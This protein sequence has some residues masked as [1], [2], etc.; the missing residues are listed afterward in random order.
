MQNKIVLLDSNDNKL[1]GDIVAI[2]KNENINYVAYTIPSSREKS[3]LLVSKYEKVGD[4]FH[5]YP[6]E[7]EKEWTFIEEYLNREV[8]G[9]DE[10]DE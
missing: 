4:I 1:E 2:F 8:F 5:I 10:F 7:A 9:G 3:D 6:I